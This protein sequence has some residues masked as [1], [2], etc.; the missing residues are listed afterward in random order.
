MEWQEITVKTEQEALEAVA[1][2]FY[3]LGS[4]GVVIEDPQLLKRMAS[5]GQWDAYELPPGALEQVHPLVKGYFPVDAHL[6]GRLE[7]LKSAIA[8]IMARLGKKPGEITFLNVEEE[9]W[10]NSWKA[11]FKPTA[12]GKRLVVRPTWESYTPREDELVLD[13]DPG[14]AFGTG[15]HATTSMCA[16]FLEKFLTPGS[17]VMDVGTGTGILAMSAA[18]LGAKDVL[19]MDFDPVAVR[20]AEENIRKNQLAG[21]IRVRQ[22][23]LLQG[24]SEKADLIVANIIAAIIIRLFPQARE[25]L[26]PG[27]YLITSGIIGE[28]KTEVEKAGLAQGFELLEETLEE[29]WVAQ[30]W[31]LKS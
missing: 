3:Q 25:H 16:R 19:A 24:I 23:D 21:V 27:G 28:R 18:L 26:V 31:R 12:I 4:G 17:K 14:M 8:E 30:V 22:N 11:F 1:D 2:V 15:G 10:A 13:L 6:P 29:D 5:S 7:K 9:D 20:V